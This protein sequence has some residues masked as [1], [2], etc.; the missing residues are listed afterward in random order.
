MTVELLSVLPESERPLMATGRR[1]KEATVEM[2]V[3]I[4]S[5]DQK[6]KESATA[7][8]QSAAME[9]AEGNGCSVSYNATGFDVM[10]PKTTSQVSKATMASKASALQIMCTL[11]FLTFLCNQEII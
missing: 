11:L 5:P 3:R 6:N 8:T 1:L 4:N 7:T 10:P 2:T 9:L